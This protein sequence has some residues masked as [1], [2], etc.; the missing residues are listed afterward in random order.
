MTELTP[1]LESFADAHRA[2]E[3][4]AS[5]VDRIVRAIV[6]GVAELPDDLRPALS[7]AVEQHWLAFL[8]RVP[9][10]AEFELVPAARQLPVEFARR[11]LG[12]PVILRIYRVAQEAS[13]EFAVEVV[14]NAP[15]ELD[16][17]ALLVWFWSKATQWFNSS[18]DESILLH[19]QEMSRIRQRGD[20]QRYEMVAGLLSGHA[21]DPAELSAT[22]GG[23]PVG[24]S[25]IALIARAMTADSISLLEPTL[26]RLA[27]QIDRARAVVVRPG[28]REVWVWL[29]S[30]SLPE[31]DPTG[32]NPDA[33]RVTA[34][35][36][37]AT[38]EG[39]T[40]AHRDA[41]A[42]QS[43]ALSAGWRQPL[44]RYDDVAVLTMLAHDHRAAERFT[45]RTLGELATKG[46][47]KLRQTTRA[48]LSTPGGADSVATALGVHKNTVRYRVGQAE[49][50]LGHPLQTR[51]GE[52]LLALDYYDAF[53]A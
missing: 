1:W 29:H 7:E 28:G 24:G 18:V 9:T 2:R 52:L 45:R 35:G 51:A 12:L 38:V 53:L 49:R 21:E 44:T 6:D 5:W 8:D 10:D 39:F 23:Y 36:P 40:E 11:H 42:A 30:R 20:T 26:L 31:L 17:E 37:A 50:L 15:G 13:W 16:H 46:A 33:V 41:R 25:H 19:Q 14:R 43:V 48:A 22:L 4:V 3:E 34:G 27:G 47:G 32:I